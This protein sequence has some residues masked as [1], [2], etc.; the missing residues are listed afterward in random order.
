VGHLDKTKN[1]MNIPLK[2]K[3]VFSLTSGLIFALLTSLTN[4]F[5]LDEMFSWGSFVFKLIFFGFF[6]GF[7]IF[8]LLKKTTQK[9]M[10]KI[11]IKLNEDED[12]RHVGP[13]TLFLGK[14][15][16]SGKLLLTNKR[17]TFKSLKQNIQSGETQLVLDDIKEA[18]PGNTA[19][20]FH[21]RM[22]ILNK[23]GK[24]FEFL[25]YE[26]DSWI[27]KINTPQLLDQK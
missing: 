26:G 23:T 18:S 24:Y 12:V 2:S 9:N 4:H 15:K 13:A 1:I 27:E 7:W 5:F 11:Q 8:Y 22:R 6:F 25:V 17:L 19:I 16:V 20:L 21:N 14:E 10:R 3:L